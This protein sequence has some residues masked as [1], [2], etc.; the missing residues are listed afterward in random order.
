ME[1]AA[2]MEWIVSPENKTKHRMEI[3]VV[4]LQAILSLI[5]V[6]TIILLIHKKYGNPDN[7]KR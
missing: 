7:Q 4:H 3:L 1:Y 2:V 6:F 5:V